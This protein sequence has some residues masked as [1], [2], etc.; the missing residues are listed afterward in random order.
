MVFFVS[1]AFSGLHNV[2]SIRLLCGNHK[3]RLS[4]SIFTSNLHRVMLLRVE[5]CFLENGFPSRLFENLKSLKYLYILY[6]GIEGV[7]ANDTLAGLINLLSLNIWTPVENGRLPS[8]FFDGLINLNTIDL[9]YT[10]LIFIPANMFNGLASL[11][12]IVLL[13]NEL[14]TLLPGLFDGLRSLT[15]VGLSDN[16]WH[17][18]CGLRWLLDW[19]NITG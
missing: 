18:S 4:R 10:T 17:C 2:T 12:Q 5:D 3:T 9:R 6:G 13:E 15:H 11:T 8:G 14:Q 16:P 1:Q 7:I 19:S